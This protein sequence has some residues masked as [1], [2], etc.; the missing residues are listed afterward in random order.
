MGRTTAN[1]KHILILCSGVVL[2]TGC[3]NEPQAAPATPNYVVLSITEFSGGKIT[4]TVPCEDNKGKPLPDPAGQ[5]IPSA[6]VLADAVWHCG[7]DIVTIDRSWTHVEYVYF[8]IDTRPEA[9]AS[10]EAVRCI[11]QGVGFSFSAV[12]AP[13]RKDGPPSALDGDETP[14]ASLHSPKR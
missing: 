14:F 1:M 8:P 3:N 4:G 13:T 6:D 10:L 11:Q 7:G 9:P 5:C 12:V 2:L